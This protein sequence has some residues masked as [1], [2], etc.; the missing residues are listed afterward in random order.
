MV[1]KPK[2]WVD[3]VPT[4]SCS[5]GGF[6]AGETKIV[7]SGVNVGKSIYVDLEVKEKKKII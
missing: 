5:E 4:K 3:T 7:A 1:G 6:K 2:F